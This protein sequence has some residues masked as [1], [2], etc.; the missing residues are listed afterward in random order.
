[1]DIRATFQSQTGTLGLAI[2]G[3]EPK[4]GPIPGLACGVERWSVKT[5]SDAAAG[6]V[7]LGSVQQTTIRALNE[8]ATHCSGLPAARTYGEEFQVYEVIGRVTFVRLEDDRDYH[9]AV[10]DPADSSY[11]IVTEVA[12]IACQ[13]A[14]SS[15]YRAVLEAARN[16]FIDLL[17]GRS[18]SSLVGAT[19]KLRGPGF[20]DFNHGQ[21]GRSR[22]CVELHPVISIVRQ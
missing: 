10:A 21:T 16:S 14:I 5:L 4:P 20:N 2:E 19:V 11:T 13:G 18:A 7:D 3:P 6:S 22:N 12:D 9:V 1:V 8:R 17:G 15:P